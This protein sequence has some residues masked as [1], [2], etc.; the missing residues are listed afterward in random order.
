MSTRK[1]LVVLLLAI[2]TFS[3]TTTAE[4]QAA[5]K[6][7]LGITVFEA[8]PTTADGVMVKEV[9]PGTPAAKMG[10]VKGDLIVN[11]AGE[12]IRSKDHLEAA[13]KKVGV[14][15]E[16][17]M[18][19]KRGDQKKELEGTMQGLPVMGKV[20]NDLRKEQ[21]LI[22]ER[23]RL[24]RELREDKDEV[25][26]ADAMQQLATALEELPARLQAASERFKQVYP[27]GKFTIR[28]EIDIQSDAEADRVIE[29]LPGQD[30]EA[31]GA[32]LKTEPDA[33][34]DEAGTVP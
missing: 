7:H 16:F 8:D 23:K 33:E 28:I 26:L 4:E 29:L 30:D 11:F 6:S 20:I 14:G 22:D 10:L 24:Q 13:I 2:G 25:S 18:V 34:E 17:E 32:D 9:F 3:G 12:G 21:R 1:L 27:D 5:K 19:L 15:E 31:G